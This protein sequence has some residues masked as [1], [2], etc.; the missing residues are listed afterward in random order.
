MGNGNFVFRCWERKVYTTQAIGPCTPF[1][2]V[3]SALWYLIIK[4]LE[5]NYQ[6]P[7]Q[8]HTFFCNLSGY[9]SDTQFNSFSYIESTQPQIRFFDIVEYLLSVCN[10]KQQSH[11]IKTPLSPFF[12]NGSK[13]TYLEGFGSSEGDQWQRAGS[14]RHYDYGNSEERCKCHGRTS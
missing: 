2:A 10:K 14:E 13:R 4:L 5:N 6:K 11:T 12:Q 8:R 9:F 1:L 7:S 3:T